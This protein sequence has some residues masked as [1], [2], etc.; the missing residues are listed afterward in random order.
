M[1]KNM[2]EYFGTIADY[3]KD[4]AN[5]RYETEK[6]FEGKQKKAYQKPLIDYAEVQETNRG[7]REIRRCWIT[8]SLSK[9]EANRLNEWVGLTRLVKIEPERTKKDKTT[10]ESRFYILS[11]AL[12][13]Q[14]AIDATRSHWGIENK[15]HWVLDMAFREDECRV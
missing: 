3:R 8:P 1:S 12:T 4:G 6:T 9:L 13:A 10:T 7:R 2:I 11:S 14:E 5:R 15:L